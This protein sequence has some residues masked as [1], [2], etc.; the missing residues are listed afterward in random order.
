MANGA[1]A[2]DN[3]IAEGRAIAHRLDSAP[4]EGVCPAHNDHNAALA[5]LV[6][7][8][9][10]RLDTDRADARRQREDRRSVALHLL[11]WAAVAAAGAGV[12][13]LVALFKG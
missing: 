3:L 2:L 12:A 9:I 13:Y 10:V 4:A 11:Q 7:A 8:E 6:R 5:Y 1:A